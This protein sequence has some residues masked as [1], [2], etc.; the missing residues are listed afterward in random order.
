MIL[1]RGSKSLSPE[2]RALSFYLTESTDPIM[3]EVIR[4]LRTFKSMNQ[5]FAQ[6]RRE[7]INQLIEWRFEYDWENTLMDMGFDPEIYR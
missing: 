5:W 3:K 2:T 6:K 1:I 4:M 7:R